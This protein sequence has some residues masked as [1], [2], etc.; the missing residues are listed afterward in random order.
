M[1]AFTSGIAQAFSR[2]TEPFMRLPLA[3]RIFGI[4]VLVTVA[5]L[6]TAFVYGGTAAL[7]LCIV[8][9]MLEVSLSFDNAIVNARVLKKMSAFWQRMFLTVGILIAVVGMRLAFPII[10]VMIASGL[11]LSDTLTLAFQEGDPHTPGTYGYILTEA[12]PQIAAFGGAFL[13]MLFLDYFFEER[14]IKWL[15]WIERPLYKVG[16]LDTVSILITLAA[17]WIAANFLAADPYIVLEAGVLGLALYLAVNA[18]SK[19]FNVEEEDDDA[20]VAKKEVGKLA[21]TTGKAAFMLFIYLEILDASFSFDGVIGAFAIT[22]NIVII[23]LG[24][25]FIGSMWVRSIT[26]YFVRTDTLAK[27]VYLEHGAHWAIG[28]LAVILLVSIGVHVNEIITGLVGVAFIVAAFIS[29]II[30]ARRVGKLE[31]QPTEERELVN[32]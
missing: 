17:I 25:G 7:L 12:H 21:V 1:S 28:A 11:S 9:G 29:S 3:V 14:D 27:F 15:H 20:T 13:L 16:K 6:V 19:L 10:I 8:L 26:V 18:L 22:A 2:L 30:R 23:A 24:L 4:S 5:S 32:S 31:E